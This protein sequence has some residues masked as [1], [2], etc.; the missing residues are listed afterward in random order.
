MKKNHGRDIRVLKTYRELYGVKLDRLLDDTNFLLMDG[1]L[2][3]EL[4]NF[5]RRNKPKNI[6]KLYEKEGIIFLLYIFIISYIQMEYE[7]CGRNHGDSLQIYGEI[8]GE[9][10]FITHRK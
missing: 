3:T 1:F 6:M 2:E 4:V 10:N 9:G 8:Q 5:K 7:P